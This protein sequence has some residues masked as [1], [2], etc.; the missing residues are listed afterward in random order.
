MSD[1]GV[2]HPVSGLLRCKA[3]V[4]FA[5]LCGAAIGAGWSMD[6]FQPEEAEMTLG[7]LLA[8]RQPRPALWGSGSLAVRTSRFEARVAGGGDY[9]SITAPRKA[10]G[11]DLAYLFIGAGGRVGT[12]EAATFNLLRPADAYVRGSGEFDALP[13][14]CKAVQAVAEFDPSSIRRVD[15]DP[16]RLTCWVPVRSGNSDFAA[17]LLTDLGLLVSE[18][19]AVPVDA[20]LLDP[21]PK[22]PRLCVSGTYAALA[23]SVESIRAGAG[24]RKLHMALR[25]SDMHGAVVQTTGAASSR[26]FLQEQAAKSFEDKGVLSAWVEP[27]NGAGLAGFA[28]LAGATPAGEAQ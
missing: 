8:R 4:S 20:M 13:A 7:E 26:K 15:L 22:G 28:P 6:G 16:L 27:T 2:P 25:Y 17:A 9:M 11:P 23:R 19:D 24:R 1:I 5:E 12:I 21:Q 18:A 3:T 14:L 10:S